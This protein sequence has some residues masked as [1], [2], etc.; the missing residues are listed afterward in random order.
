M[1][2][3]QS[4]NTESAVGGH[5]GSLSHK[6]KILK[7]EIRYIFTPLNYL[8]PYSVIKD[9]FSGIILHVILEHSFIDSK[10]FLLSE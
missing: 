9:I 6:T 7:D 10:W 4:L 5:L 3:I 8:L 1:Y 2:I